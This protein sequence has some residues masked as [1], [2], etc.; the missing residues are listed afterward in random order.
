MIDNYGI[1]LAN[2]HAPQF[3]A[4]LKRNLVQTAKEFP[5]YFARLF[6]VTVSLNALV[7]HD[8][9]LLKFF[10]STFLFFF[11]YFFSSELVL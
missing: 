10:S 2:I 3:K 11:C 1:T 5:C 6:P 7:G 9:V 8:Q 4:T